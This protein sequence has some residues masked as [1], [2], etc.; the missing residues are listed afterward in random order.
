MAASPGRR[1]RVEI[2]PESCCPSLAGVSGSRQGTADCPSSHGWLGLGSGS[3]RLG[4]EAAS[5][6]G[7]VLRCQEGEFQPW[8]LDW[9]CFIPAIMSKSLILGR[10]GVNQLD[11]L[12][13]CYF[14]FAL[15]ISL[16]CR[17]ELL[18]KYIRTAFCFKHF[19]EERKK[20]AK[21]NWTYECHVIW[22]RKLV[23]YSFQC[24]GLKIP[25]SLGLGYFC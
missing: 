2:I 24:N 7:C 5:C 17:S 16:F 20:S 4:H 11:K 21:L 19:K 3:C 14:H 1:R 9:Q 23:S 12:P 10:G 13:L 6:Q 8:S 15:D 22:G 18:D 25:N